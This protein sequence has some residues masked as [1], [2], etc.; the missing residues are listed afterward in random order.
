V[1]AGTARRRL[2]AYYAMNRT[3]IVAPSGSRRMLNGNP[4]FATSVRLGLRGRDNGAS[5]TSVEA[6]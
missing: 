6:A 5:P 1:E 3:V 4:V 2:L